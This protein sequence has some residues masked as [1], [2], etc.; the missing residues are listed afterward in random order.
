MPGGAGHARATR[1]A[2][3]LLRRIEAMDG[4]AQVTVALDLRAGYG[5]SRM[6]DLAH[7]TGETWT[8]RSG[9]TWF[10][11]S[12]RGQG[13][14][15]GRPCSAM[16]V[17]LAEGEEHDLVLEISDREFTEEP[18]DAERCWA[19]TEEAWSQVSFPAA[20]T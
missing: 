2:A 1:T 19:A 20:R 9:G 15:A 6:T 12:G 4:A 5:R 16:R 3:V 8:G 7:G 11:W 10:R 18:P 17:E 13:A 14:A